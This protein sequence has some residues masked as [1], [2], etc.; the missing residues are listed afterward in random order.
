MS[1]LLRVVY[2]SNVSLSTD[3]ISS[4]VILA[5]RHMNL[6]NLTRRYSQ[7][8]CGNLTKMRIVQFKT[9]NDPTVRVGVIKGDTVIDINAGD[10]SL[11]NTLVGI[12]QQEGALETIKKLAA[13]SVKHH[14]VDEVKLVS[15][16][17]N[18]DKVLG[19][20]LNFKDFADKV[21][22]PYPKEPIVFSKFPSVIVGPY[23]NVPKGTASNAID[24]E[25]ELVAVIGRKAKNVKASEALDYVFGYTATQD[26]TAKD[27]ISRSGGQL[28]MCKN[29][30]G[31][32]PI[33]PCVVTKEE[34]GDP[35]KIRIRTWVNGVLKQNGNTEN[36]ICRIDKIVEY[37]SSA[38][39][40]LPGDV[41]CTGTPYGVGSNQ[42]PPQYLQEGDLLETEVE[43]VGKLSNRIINVPKK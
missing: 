6:V 37:L 31:F 38:M 20:A 19:V 36:M 35:H 18:P 30:D 9:E 17:T 22:A 29:M 1:S 25:G 2:R 10:K 39:T 5:K 11:P 14:L 3:H 41:I 33:G 7:S 15:P 16:I 12:L 43:N 13:K 40:L 42:N 28:I 4:A 26:L 34:L 24:W 32:S 27:W 8:V 21:G 23:D